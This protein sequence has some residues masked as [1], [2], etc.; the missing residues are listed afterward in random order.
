[1]LESINAIPELKD[2]D[3]VFSQ[4]DSTGHLT[5]PI[6]KELMVLRPVTIRQGLEEESLSREAL[7]PSMTV[8]PE[9]YVTFITPNRRQIVAQPTVQNQAAIQEALLEAGITQMEFTADGNL[10]LEVGGETHTVRPDLYT[11]TIDPSL[12]L[13]FTAKPSP[14]VTGVNEIVFRFKD[15]NGIHREQKF[16]PVPAHQAELRSQFQGYPGANAVTFFNNG[17][18]SIKIG[19]RTYSAVFDYLV[20]SGEPNHQVTQLLF[21]P[22]INGDNSQDVKIFYANGDE[23]L[24]YVM[25]FPEIS[26]EIQD[27]EAV[28][29]ADY[30]VSQDIYGNYLLEKDDTQWLMTVSKQEPADDDTPPGMEIQPDGSVIFVTPSKLKVTMQPTMQDLPALEGALGDYGI[31]SVVVQENGNIAIPINDTLSAS[32]RPNLTSMPAWFG[33]QLGLHNFPTILP[34]VLNVVLV[35]LD[36]TAQKRMQI[37]YPAAKYPQ[38]AN[39]FFRDMP[40]VTSV[41]FN[42]DGTLSE[43]GTNLNFRGIFSYAVELGEVAATGSLQVIDIPDVNGDS[44]DDFT[45]IYETGERQVIYQIPEVSF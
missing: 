1:L 34:G 42:N 8:H 15:D 31:T 20:T 33:L 41:I 37:L 36:D 18:V 35:Y 45:L 6:G 2:N 44:V 17:K 12:P 30:A 19:K 39:Q 26:A 11:Y 29:S 9:G 7:K 21:V 25:P 38:K 5:L 23:Q 14:V 24:L 43:E 10:R 3:L 40:G 32:T 28:Q 13:G 22:D 16:Y 27:I 4:S